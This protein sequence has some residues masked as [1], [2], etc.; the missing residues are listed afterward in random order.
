MIDGFGHRSR[1][2]QSVD[3]PREISRLAWKLDPQHFVAEQNQI[4][5]HQLRGALRAH[6]GAIA[7]AEILEV[8]ERAT[9]LEEAYFEVMGVRPDRDEA[10]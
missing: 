5:V 2:H 1:V 6:V 10:A 3:A 7:G 9:T 8:H 4:A